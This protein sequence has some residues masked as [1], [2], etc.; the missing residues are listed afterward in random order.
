MHKKSNATI[1]RTVYF[2]RSDRD[3]HSNMKHAEINEFD[4]IKGKI[5]KSFK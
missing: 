5:I 4:W 2:T 3:N 1:A